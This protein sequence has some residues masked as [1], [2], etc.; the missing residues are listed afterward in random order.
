MIP[1]SSLPAVM[2]SWSPHTHR[3]DGTT[4]PSRILHLATGSEQTL[5][6]GLVFP[7][8]PLLALCFQDGFNQAG[9][10]LDSRSSGR[11]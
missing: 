4:T 3:L 10:S 1:A 6:Q 8:R 2:S 11:A 5:S 7:D 9:P